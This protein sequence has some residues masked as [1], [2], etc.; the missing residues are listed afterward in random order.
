MSPL[1]LIAGGAEAGTLYGIGVGPGDVRYLTLRAAGLIRSVDVLACF[2]KEGRE[3]CA[4]SVAAP[5]I[6]PGR[7]ELTLYYPVT[8]EA[9]VEDAAYTSP[10]RDF[11]EAS[12]ERLAALLRAGRS[13]GLM[14]EGDPFFY[15]SFMHMWRRLERDFPVEIVPGVIGISG[16]AAKANA[17]LTWGDDVLTVLPGTL[18]EATLARRLADTDAAAI[19]KVGRNLAKVR[20]AVAQAGLLDRA[21]YVERGTM[22]GE[23]VA[24]LADVD[25]AKA[26]YF[27]MILIPGNGRRI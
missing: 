26:P 20:R 16:C 7:E 9:P 17:P 15:G 4:R 24:P 3:S 10:M 11:Y 19:M 6:E 12:A 22:P 13:V 5:L 21:I 14:G 8:T 18:D 27:S 1:E 2:A 25:A 23:R